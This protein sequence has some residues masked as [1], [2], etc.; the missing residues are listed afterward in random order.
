MIWIKQTM[1]EWEETGSGPLWHPLLMGGSCWQGGGRS[2][3]CVCAFACTNCSSGQRRRSRLCSFS[4]V[5]QSLLNNQVMFVSRAT[6][7]IDVFTKQVISRSHYMLMT[8]LHIGVTGK[9]LPNQRC[10]SV[11][12][13]TFVRGMQDIFKESS[14]WLPVLSAATKTGI[15]SQHMFP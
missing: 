15:L 11:F 5:N 4:I 12:V 6:Y 7:H 14:C 10:S 3:H 1:S 13:S 8:W 9:R 2:W